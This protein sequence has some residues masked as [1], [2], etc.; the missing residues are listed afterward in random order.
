MHLY[1]LFMLRAAIFD[2]DGVIVDNHIYHVKAWETFCNRHGLPFTENDF[3]RRFFGKT[4]L[5]IFRG[6]IGND[7]SIP[8]SE[9]MGEEK[10]AIYREIYREHIKPVEGLADLLKGFKEH[11]ILTAVATSAPTSNLDFVVDTLALRDLF[12]AFVDASMITHGKPHPEIYLKAASLLNADPVN[13]IVF[14]DSVSGIKSGHAA[15]MRVVALATTHSPN[16]LPETALLVK[17]FTGLS[18]VKLQALF[19]G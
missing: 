2:M 13:C 8:D 3:R 9:R 14:E 17:N 1:S 7:I 4:N 19:G 10:E 18:V 11:G 6:L 16:E 12:T 15:G 5:D